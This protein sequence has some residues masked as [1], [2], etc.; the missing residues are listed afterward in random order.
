MAAG[1]DIDSKKWWLR[2]DGSPTWA[3]P[4]GTPIRTVTRRIVSLLAA[5]VL[6]PMTW[7]FAADGNWIAV[8]AIPLAIALGYVWRDFDVR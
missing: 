5:V 8:A 7:G 4:K 1:T 2:A 6:A 3:G